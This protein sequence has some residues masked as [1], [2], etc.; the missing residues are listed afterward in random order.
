MPRCK[1]IV[2]I[3]SELKVEAGKP[4]SVDV[5]L[6]TNMVSVGVDVSRLGLMVMNGQPKTRSEYIQATSRVGRREFPGLVVAVLNAAKPRDRSQ[7]IADQ[8]IKE[9]TPDERKIL[10]RRM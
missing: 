5:V 4:G 1:P 3:L 7:Q 9:T 8:H 2:E 10:I 6:A